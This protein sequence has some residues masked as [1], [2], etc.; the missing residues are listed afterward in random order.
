MPKLLRILSLLDVAQTPDDLAIPSLR[1]HPLKGDL[2]GQWSVWVL[3][4]LGWPCNQRMTLLRSELL[5]CPQ[6]GRWIRSP[7]E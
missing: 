1:T 3:P 6:S 7:E 5:D 4:A 2:A